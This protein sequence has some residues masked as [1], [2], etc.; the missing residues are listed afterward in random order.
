MKLDNS[1][2]REIAAAH[3]VGADDDDDHVG[4]RRHH[5][6]HGVERAPQADGPDPGVA[7][8][9]GDLRQPF[10]L[11][12]LGP[13]GLD[14]LDPSKLSWTPAESLPSSPWAA[15]KWRSTRRW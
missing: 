7:D 1:P 5:V 12:P 10:G 6:E 14:E 13:V 2:T 11:A 15:S 9:S 3:A 4:E 8:A